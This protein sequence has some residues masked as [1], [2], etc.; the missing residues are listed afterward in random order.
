MVKRRKFKILNLESEL[1]LRLGNE[2]THT[3][4]W[5]VLKEVG[6]KLE[7]LLFSIAESKKD[8]MQV[9]V[10]E[11]FK[12]EFTGF[13]KGSSVPAFVFRDASQQNITNTDPIKENV[14]H[15]F[16]RLMDNISRGDYRELLS[17]FTNKEQNVIVKRVA[18][19]I[20]SSGDYGMAIVK[21]KSAGSSKFIPVY[22][23]R[24]FTMQA[25]SVLSKREKEPALEE[26]SEVAFAKLLLNKKPGGRIKQKTVSLYRESEMHFV[27][28]FKAIQTE[29]RVYTLKHPELFKVSQEGKG[30][31]LENERL[32]IYAAGKS[33]ADAETDMFYQFDATYQR[34]LQLADDKLSDRLLD[35]KR[36]YQFIIQSVNPS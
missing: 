26:N 21:R 29:E 25:V 3:I 16:S 10:R 2:D 11:E 22:N 18:D 34:F 33:V 5:D 15:E 32:D 6:N 35:V 28:E 12:L 13:Y 36:Y 19:F 8:D 24:N 14:K 31:L 20:N 27:K 1:L 17:G 30:I 4:P 23:L 9:S 7:A